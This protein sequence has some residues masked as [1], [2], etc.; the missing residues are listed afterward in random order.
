MRT[1]EAAKIRKWKKENRK[2]VKII[3]R[4]RVEQRKHNQ[5][6]KRTV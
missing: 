6:N 5:A 1:Q 4:K 3:Y 2:K